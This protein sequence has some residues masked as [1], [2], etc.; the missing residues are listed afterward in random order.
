MQGPPRITVGIGA[1]W[2]EHQRPAVVVNAS[3][4]IRNVIRPE[5]NVPVPADQ[6]ADDT[7][8]NVHQLQQR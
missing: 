2:V 3:P 6:D 8:D 1:P 7:P 5:I 4:R